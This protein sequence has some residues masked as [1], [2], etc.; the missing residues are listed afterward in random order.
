[1]ASS[2]ELLTAPLTI[3]FLG[4]MG[5]TT[6]ETVTLRNFTVVRIPAQANP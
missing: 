1:V 4:K 3:D 5:A 6:G 2:S